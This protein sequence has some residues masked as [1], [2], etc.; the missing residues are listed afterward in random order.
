MKPPARTLKRKRPFY[1]DEDIPGTIPKSARTGKAQALAIEVENESALPRD[2]TT[3]ETSALT[4][5]DDVVTVTSATGIDSDGSKDASE[6]GGRFGPQPLND[7]YYNKSE[8]KS[9]V[10][11]NRSA[12]IVTAYRNIIEILIEVANRLRYVQ[13]GDP[14]GG[15]GGPHDPSTIHASTPGNHYT[16]A[17][18]NSANGIYTTPYTNPEQSRYVTPYTHPSII[19]EPSRNR[20]LNDHV[21]MT[22]ELQIPEK[23]HTVSEGSKSAVQVTKKARLDASAPEKTKR[24]KDSTPVSLG[25]L[26][27]FLTLAN[28]GML[29]GQKDTSV[30]SEARKAKHKN[31]T[32]TLFAPPSPGDT[33]DENM[34]RSDDDIQA[35]VNYI[36]DDLMLPQQQQ[37]PPPQAPAANPYAAFYSSMNGKQLGA[38]LK[39]LID[40]VQPEVNAVM[41]REQIQAAHLFHTHLANCV[42]TRISLNIHPVHPNPFSPQTATN[43]WSSPTAYAPPPPP[44]PSQGYIL[45]PTGEWQPFSTSPQ[46]PPPALAPA[47]VPRGNVIAPPEVRDFDEE[48]KVATFGFPPVPSP[49]SGLRSKGGGGKRQKR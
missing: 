1:L 12:E 45:S 38:E 3:S 49:R 5:A 44:P 41:V 32:S 6:N 4:S 31:S 33:I 11:L 17:Y 10:E 28:G 16:T 29:P 9:P 35:L 25:M 23:N 40:V 21:L 36:A 18:A 15:F 13:P 2:I 48:R 30:E 14:Y 46:Q 20:Q 42:N 7:L 8:I 37:P 34:S 26:D 24:D 27:G 43:P 39:R 19:A 47:F 22:A